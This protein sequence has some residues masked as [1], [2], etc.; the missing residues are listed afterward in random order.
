M[1]NLL[2]DGC[3]RLLKA[4]LIEEAA[5]EGGI[6][7][8][9]EVCGGDHDAGQGDH[10]SLYGLRESGLRCRLRT[11][12]GKDGFT[13]PLKRMGRGPLQEPRLRGSRP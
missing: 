12:S 3:I 7:V 6:Q 1:P 10:T 5:L 9:R 4:D 11:L 8:L 2:A 13:L